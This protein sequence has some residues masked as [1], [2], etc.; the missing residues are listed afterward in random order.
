MPQSQKT[1]NFALSI[2][3]G[4]ARGLSGVGVLRFFQEEGLKPKLVA[5]SSAGAILAG[6][7]ALGMKWYEL[8]EEL[9]KVNFRELIS[10]KSF[11]TGRSVVDED[12]FIKRFSEFVN[13]DINIEDLPVKFVA[14]ASDP[15]TRERVF[16]DHGNLFRAIM[17]SCAYPVA[18]PSPIR[19]DNKVL[20]DGDLTQSYSA[21]ELKAQYNI[22]KVI[23][24]RHFVNWSR[25]LKPTSGF[26]DEI[27]A[28]YRLIGGQIE[29]FQ[30]HT[31]PADLE[32]AF[33]VDG[34]GY[35]SFNTIEKY[36]EKAYKATV[37]MREQIFKLL[38]VKHHQHGK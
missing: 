36:A 12:K 20:V 9:Q 24:I 13:K 38:N 28:I 32:I 14:F 22:D 33:N 37:A 18:F 10:F 19:M 21:K 3:G 16:I 11:I 30:A 5:G 1:V 17:C 7:Y 6:M 29:R 2:K 31:D 35:T 23:G 26:I 8:V 4:L 15:N 27:I 34:Q 25:P